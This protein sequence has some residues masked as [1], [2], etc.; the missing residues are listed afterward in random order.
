MIALLCSILA[1][2]SIFVIFKIFPKFKIDTFQA[3]VFN[4]ITAFV[5]GIILF[6]H[7][8]N[9]NSLSQ[10]NWIFHCLMASILFISLF[11]VMGISSQR[12]GVAQTSIAVKMSMAL[13][14]VL[15][16]FFFNN[17]KES[18]S[19]S[20][21]LGFVLAIA[22]VF[23]SSFEKKATN[24]NRT[25]SWMLIVLFIGSSLLDLL[26]KY[27][28]SNETQHISP[29][30][31]SAFGLGCAGLIGLIIFLIRGIQ[32]KM[33]F[34]FRNVWAG[35]LLGIPNYFSIYLLMLSYS[36]TGWNSSAVLAI[37]NVSVVLLTSIIG[38]SI[39]L[40]KITPLKIIGLIAAIGAILLI[41]YAN[42]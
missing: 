34:E 25:A 6:G 35:I 4:Y 13:S 17:T 42:S 3:I 36:S 28:E 12:N 10:G 16:L 1:S 32:G 41:Y 24:D 23:L 2:T 31:F 27:V 19:I 7:T 14:V 9:S 22:G 26:L 37:T 20:L 21:V 39:F 33:K 40:E 18:I 11:L 29:A 8:F 5:A 15:I 30:L 38:F